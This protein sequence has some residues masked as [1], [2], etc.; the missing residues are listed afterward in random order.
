MGSTIE[1]G[2]PGVPNSIPGCVVEDADWDDLSEF[3]AD[4]II[5][6]VKTT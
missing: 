3:E 6:S 1:T 2:Q 4:G 5:C